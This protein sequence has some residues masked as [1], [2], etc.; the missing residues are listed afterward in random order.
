MVFVF[1]KF[2]MYNL[3]VICTNTYLRCV[4]LKFFSFRPELLTSPYTESFQL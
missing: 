3:S 1:L 4:Q 2:T